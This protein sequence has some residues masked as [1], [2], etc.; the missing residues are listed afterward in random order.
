ML[1]QQP[2]T[3]CLKTGA[4]TRWKRWYNNYIITAEKI[5]KRQR[6]HFNDNSWHGQIYKT[7]THART[8]SYIRSIHLVAGTPLE[9]YAYKDREQ[10]FVNYFRNELPVLERRVFLLFV[11]SPLSF[12]KRDDVVWFGWLMRF[13][14]S[15]RETYEHCTWDSTTIRALPLCKFRYLWRCCLLNLRGKI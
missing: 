12:Y 6:T 11:F 8:H 4:R 3:R 14:G 1:R 13:V 5:K 9:Q 15:R 7:H 10:V 2:E